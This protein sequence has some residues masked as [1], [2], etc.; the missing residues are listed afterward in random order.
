LELLA[1]IGR[2]AGVI[3]TIDAVNSAVTVQATPGV[4]NLYLGSIDDSLAFSRT[5]TLSPTTDLN[6]AVIG[7]VDVVLTTSGL[8]GTILPDQDLAGIDIRA[9]AYGTGDAPAP[10]QLNFTGPYPQTLEA[11]GSPDYLLDLIS[12][13]LSTL[14][15]DLDASI[16]ESSPLAGLLDEL[17]LGSLIDTLQGGL[18]NGLLE[19]L[20]LGG[21]TGGLDDLLNSLLGGLLDDSSDLGN[22]LGIEVGKMGVTVLGV[23]ELCP[24]LTIAKSHSGDFTAG[25]PGSYAINVRNIGRT[26]TAGDITVVDTL[27]AGMS[28]AGHTGSGWSLVSVV[29]SEVTWRHSGPVAVNGD[30]SPWF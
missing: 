23:V 21:G 30:L 28:Y 27:P 7:E 25:I 26:A 10:V 15:L 24:D 4:T 19:D 8:L 2:G 14:E 5:H 9:R 1:E 22:L 6:F 16:L 11:T 12:D 17:E 13:L 3:E 20:N 18:L 29:N